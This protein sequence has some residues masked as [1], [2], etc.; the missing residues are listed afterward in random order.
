M[1]ERPLPGSRV[2][3]VLVTYRRPH[4]L[5]TML[6]RLSAQTLVFESLFVVD[7]GGMPETRELLRAHETGP[8]N[9]RL[10][11]PGDNLGPAGGFALGMRRVLEVA[12]PDDWILLLDDDNPP[13]VGSSRFLTDLATFASRLAAA[14]PET[15]AVG[16]GG[17]RFDARRGRMIRIVDEELADVVPVDCIAN[18][19]FPLYRTA[20]VR[21]AGVQD[22]RLFFGFGELEYG[23]RLRAAGYRL[24]LAGAFCRARR[25]GGPRSDPHR[26]GAPWRQYY[27]VRNLVHLLRVS[28]HP[29]AAARVTLAQGL[30]RPLV[31]RPAGSRLATLR[32]TL[33]GA[34]DGWRG[35]LGRVVEPVV[36]DL[37]CP[38]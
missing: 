7:N 24:Y 23:L 1:G 31:T 21:A 26:L 29:L 2:F 4:A 37:Q 13:P 36:A 12:R 3:G 11:A 18:S 5:A 35:R 6:A 20:A 22:G 33:R 9:A 16:A 27:G 14:D 34:G 8:L 17:A 30:L 15:G 32:L 38:Q 25:A 10:I 28:G 19:L